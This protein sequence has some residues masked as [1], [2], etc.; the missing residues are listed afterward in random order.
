MAHPGAFPP[1]LVIGCRAH[2]VPWT[3]VAAKA[4]GFYFE[5][6]LS[7]Q[8]IV[9]AAQTAP[10]RHALAHALRSTTALAMVAAGLL[11]AGGLTY[12]V[13]ASAKASRHR[14]HHHHHHHHVR[15]HAR[16]ARCGGANTP[17]YRA[18]NAE[19]RAAV[20]CLINK[21]RVSKGLPALDGSPQLDRSA[22]GWTDAMVASGQFTHG[23]PG[24]RVSAVGFHWST[25]G[26]N[27]AT[28]FP[29]PRQVVSAWMASQG[30]CQNILDPVYSNVGTGVNK[31]AVRGFANRAGT[32]TQDFGL[33]MG[34]RAP[35]NN[36]G[37]WSHCPY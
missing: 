31:G 12:A 32:W 27:I 24:A 20:L 36:W 17:A 33:Q 10:L 14:H 15:R 37:P 2:R 16:N 34:R 26:E 18:S 9:L 5:L 25:V 11:V 13:P 28:G 1:G 21:I 30:H 23:D 35:S 19:L 3:D 8:L 22:Q 4:P 6:D 29:T 7:D